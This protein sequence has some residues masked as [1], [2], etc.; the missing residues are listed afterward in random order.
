MKPVPA[1]TLGAIWDHYGAIGCGKKDPMSRLLLFILL[2][3]LSSASYAATGVDRFGSLGW[4]A[5][6]FCL[7]VRAGARQQGEVARR[8]LMVFSPEPSCMGRRLAAE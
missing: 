3:A 2:A 7:V 6:R 4:P 1:L 5:L 8:K